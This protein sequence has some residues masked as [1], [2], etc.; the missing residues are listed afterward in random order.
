M[1][2]CVV[3]SQLPRSVCWMVVQEHP[4]RHCAITNTLISAGVASDCFENIPQA[5][6]KRKTRAHQAVGSA[7]S[8]LLQNTP[9]DRPG[10]SQSHIKQQTPR[11]QRSCQ[12]RKSC[13]FAMYCTPTVVVAHPSHAN[14]FSFSSCFPPS[15]R[16]QG[17]FFF[18]P[19]PCRALKCARS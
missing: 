18:F 13:F 9:E 10:N 1:C 8:D 5:N 6:K 12:Q 2:T 7:E 3:F 17:G 4:Y 11:P 19:R 15:L 16:F 14:I